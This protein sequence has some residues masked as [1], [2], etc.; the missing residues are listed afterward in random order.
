MNEISIN[1][2]GLYAM[3]QVR[4][5]WKMGGEAFAKMEKGQY[6]IRGLSINHESNDYWK[7]LDKLAKSGY[8]RVVS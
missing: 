1:S 2:L 4:N 8:E 5:I 6:V 3:T 7:E